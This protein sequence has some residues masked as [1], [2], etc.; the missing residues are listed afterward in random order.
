MSWLVVTPARNEAER[1]PRLAKSLAALHGDYIGHWIVVDDGSTDGTRDCVP[2]DLP[3][4]VTVLSRTNDGGLGHG[5]PWGAWRFGTEHGLTLLPDATRVLKV[6]ADVELDPDCFVQLATAD[7]CGM[8]GAVIGGELEKSVRRDHVRGGVKSYSR[9]AYEIVR[10]F[11]LALGFDVLDEVAIRSAGMEVRLVPT[12]V[13]WVT[14]LTG[15][16]E[17]LL[18]GRQRAGKVARWTG[19][20]PAYMLLRVIRY[21]WRRPYVTG[22]AATAWGYLVA[23]PGPY[24]AELKR[25][26]RREQTARLRHLLAHPAEGL[27]LYGFRS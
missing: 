27:R 1:L 13:S 23:G 21:L 24:S 26:N 6:D 25:A 5:S 10:T 18:R 15:S 16:S 14:R 3:F 4:P 12:A 22:A 8:S 2:T 17:G 20:H 9:E 19:Y 7:D 11:P